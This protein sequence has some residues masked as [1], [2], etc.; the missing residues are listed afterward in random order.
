MPCG[1]SGKFLYVSHPF[2]RL[3]CSSFSRKRTSWDDIFER[4]DPHDEEFDYPIAVRRDRDRNILDLGAEPKPYQYGLVGHVIPPPGSTSP[5]T[6]SHQPAAAFHPPSITTSMASSHSRNTSITPLLGA[7]SVPEKGPRPGGSIQVAAQ[8]AQR[9]PSASATSQ[10][11]LGPRSLSLVSTTSS[12]PLIDGSVPLSLGSRIDEFGS[13]DAL[14]RTGSPVSVVDR[15]VLQIIGDPPQSPVP[16]VA[17]SSAHPN[18]S[19]APASARPSKGVRAPRA[20]TGVVQHTD[21]GQAP[22]NLGGRSNEPPPY[23][24]V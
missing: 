20:P 4:E 11:S 7:G 10:S 23:S 18:P 8:S 21:A 2:P 16:S 6:G 22:A 19:A 1:T 15:R 14:N 9:Q 17:P 3:T 5:S 24:R 12:A 13:L